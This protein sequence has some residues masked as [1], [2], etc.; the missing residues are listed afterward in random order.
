MEK[1]KKYGILILIIL[2]LLMFL[3]NMFLINKVNNQSKKF[4]NYENTI[5]ALNSTIQHS[6]ENGIDKWSKKTP[7]I[8]LKDLVNSEYFK[9]M[10]SEQQKFYLDLQKVKGLISSTKIELEKQGQMLGTLQAGTIEK[11]STGK[12]YIKFALND[13]LNFVE[14]D[15][16]KKLQWNA[17]VIMSNPIKFNT[18]YTYLPTIQSSFIRNKDKSITVEYVIDD[19]ELKVKNMNNF[20]IP[21][22]NDTRGP[23]KKWLN[24]NKIPLSITAGTAVFIGGT[25]VGYKLAK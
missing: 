15:T 6:V 1:L 22:E 10:S 20:I 23:L 7:E 3:T 24:K 5:S 11:D 12:E 8:I 4:D 13:T 9:T 17:N 16:T 14:K 18:E 21:I 2:L 25:Y 19:P